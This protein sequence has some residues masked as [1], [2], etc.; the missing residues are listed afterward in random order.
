M[1][2][3]KYAP[4][5][6][7][8]WIVVGCG[9]SPLPSAFS[10]RDS[11]GVQIS[12]SFRP[13]WGEGRGWCIGSEPLLRL[14]VVDGNA[15]YQFDGITGMAR[16]EDG[17]IVVADAGSQ[18]VRFFG[19][20]GETKAAVGGEGEGPGEFLGLSGLGRGPSG[21]VWAYD[22]SLRRITW[23]DA[24]GEVVGMATLA[25][26]PPILNPVGPLSDGTFVLKQLWGA[27][28]VAQADEQ[29]FRRDPVAFVRFD[30]DGV[31]LD[32]LGLFP[33]RE[34]V[35]TEEGG[36]G[37]MS[38][39]PF[40]RNAVGTVLGGEVVVGIQ[41][42]FELIRYS[43]DGSM[44]GR[45]RIPNR[46]LSITAADLDAYIAGRLSTVAEDRRP[47]LRHELE[48]MP[49]PS[50][51]PAFGGLLGDELGDLWVAEWVLYPDVPRV[52]TV[53]DSRGAWLGE[54]EI[55]G[56]FFPNAIGDDWILG[57]EWDDLDVEYVALYPLEKEE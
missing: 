27:V 29:G 43:P 56:R 33:G 2:L 54:V 36:R 52:W 22:F 21:R 7:A 24:A 41:D 46:N 53:L 28:A 38:T 50:S 48:S 6:L 4:M 12:E 19:P 20:G 14:G 39:P 16:L 35:L 45:V 13:A 47:G 42:T 9:D 55:P 26:E 51:K 40:A 10:V 32:T 31:L 1:D 11:S 17:T 57:V 3:V 44:V 18:E 8:S 34:V 49:T 5:A 30:G 15:A 25:P 37:V 23:L